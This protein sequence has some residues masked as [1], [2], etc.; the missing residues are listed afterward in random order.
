MKYFIG[1]NSNPL[2][3][4]S[5]GKF[6]K[7]TRFIHERR[8]L[9]TFVIFI[10]LH[11]SVYIRQDGIR[12]TLKQNQYLLLFS[13]HEH[14]GYRESETPV[15]YYWCHFKIM[16]NAY[17]IINRQE[18]SDL[19]TSHDISASDFFILPEYG[20]LSD[21]VRAIQ[22]FHQ[23]LDI[24]R[25]KFYSDNLPN[26][27]LSLLAMEVSQ[28]FIE[29]NFITNTGGELNPNMEK[30]I[31]WVRVNYNQPL[32][33]EIIGKRFNYNRDYLSAVFKKYKGVPLM[34]YILLFRLSVAKKLL[35]NTMDTVKEVAWKVGFRDERVF[36]KQFKKIEDTTPTKYRNAFSRIKLVK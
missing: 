18:L 3:Y 5:S 26:Y 33:L 10:C 36:M 6:V 8:N 13:G 28:E 22:I 2:I 14:A 30:I 35:L 11:G 32:S 27:A 24:S 25:G 12:Y 23:L 29:Q 7:N 21:N 34:K 19:F 17:Q 31:E 1:K 16:N 4:V 20:D 9:D 15:S